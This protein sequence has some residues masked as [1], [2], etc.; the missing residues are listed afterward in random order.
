MKRLL[1]AVSILF[2]F[3]NIF[4]QKTAKYAGTYS[5]NWTNYSRP[6]GFLEV[7]PESDTSLLF[8]IE[9]G[10]GEPS[11]NTGIG[12]GRIIKKKDSA[13]FYMV[14]RDFF[15]DCKLYFKFLNGKI[16]IKTCGNHFDCGYGHGV[17]SDGTYYLKNRK[18]PKYFI[19]EKDTIYFND[20]T[21]K[22]WYQAR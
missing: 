1:I 13:I 19:F 16:I 2:L 14:N 20:K 11:E 9:N 22:K 15:M 18:I 10:K 5:Y 4:G 8:Y 3:G 6:F 12:Y 17:Y 21:L 7:Y